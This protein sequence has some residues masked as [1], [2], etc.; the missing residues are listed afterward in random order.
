MKN[1]VLFLVFNR[2]D[3]TKLVFES[4]RA[5]KP[6]RLYISSDGPRIDRPNDKSLCNRVQSIVTK[7]DWPCE[8]KTF[9]RQNNQGCKKA[10]SSGIDWFFKNEEQGIILEDDTLPLSGFFRYCDELLE[11][12]KNDDRVG[13]ISGFNPISRSHFSNESYFFTHYGNIWG[14][15]T[16]RRAWQHYDVD[17]CDWPKWRDDGKLTSISDSVPFFE[18][19][20]KDYNNAIYNRKIDTWDFQWYFTCWKINGLC[21]TPKQ[22]QI[23]NLGFDGN[24]THTIGKAPDFVTESKPEKLVFPLVHPSHVERNIDADILI[25]N[26]V[27]KIK[28]MTII[29][30]KIRRVPLLGNLASKIKYSL[31]LNF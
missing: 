23:S 24:A 20:W 11:F 17:M 9:V 1:P 18:A 16:W 7:I 27:F 30:N 19:Y 3:T 8:L 28:L 31:N 22:N 6:P 26:R 2:P 14:W 25:S 13:M 4:I 29:A 5:A 12:Y 15:A 21:I 10:V